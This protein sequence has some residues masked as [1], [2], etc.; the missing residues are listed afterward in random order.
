VL[1]VEDYSNTQTRD[2]KIIQYQSAFVIGD[3]V[4]HFCIYNESVEDNWCPFLSIRG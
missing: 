2:A 3:F 1:E 4:D